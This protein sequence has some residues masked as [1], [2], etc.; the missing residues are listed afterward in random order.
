LSETEAK[1]II[2]AIEAC[3]SDLDFE[4]LEIELNMDWHS[5]IFSE[6]E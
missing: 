3:P 1:E 5:I 2:Q 6:S 4:V